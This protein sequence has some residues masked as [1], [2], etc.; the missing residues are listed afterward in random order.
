MQSRKKVELALNHESGPIPIDLGSN[1]V[2]GIH[3]SV[4]A[5]LRRHYGLEDRPVKV[6]E[7]YQML[8]EVEPDLQEAIGI[9][10]AGIFPYKT[11]FGFTNV[12]WKEWR[13]PWGQEVL[14]PGDFVTSVDDNGDTLIYP[15]GDREAPPS[16]RMPTNGF[17]FDT[18][19]RQEPIDDENL[20][21]EDNLE[22]FGPIS[23]E[24][25]SY[26]ESEA[27]RLEKTG[28]AVMA[29]FGGTGLG[30]IALVPAPF[31][32]HPKGIRD[33]TEWYIST[34][35]R[36]DY[37]HEIFRRQSDI[38]LENLERVHGVVGE[39]PDVV[40]LCG[41]DFGT[42]ESTFCSPETFRELYAPYYKKMNDWIH[43]N[44]SWKVFKHS[45][46]AVANFMPLFIEAG[47]D[48][49]NPVQISAKG[50]DR[51]HLKGEFGDNLVF[52][53]GGVDTQKTLAFGSPE[54]VKADVIKSCRVFGQGGGFVFNA[55]HNVQAR[56]S[57]ENVV[58]MIEAVREFNRG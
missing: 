56:S 46:G 17:F 18:I 57:T 23:D 41:T 21:V 28:R 50:M 42:Q 22:E 37:V 6:N 1:A 9:D 31:A 7:P 4:V 49:I 40:F 13:T 11:M 2:T 16:G 14:V 58:S 36:Q 33:V 27:K 48:I 30:D 43:A 15:A 35:A 34:V 29:N 47:F 45:C 3:A 12:G 26:Y 10:V 20:N 55:V 54:E 51:E 19:I 39:I 44:T 24:E 5:E 38:A 8:G 52:W 25:L 53:G 32:R